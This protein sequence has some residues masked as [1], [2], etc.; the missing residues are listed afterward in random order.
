M[1][2]HS[3]SILQEITESVPV[4][5]KKN[6]VESKAVHAISSAIA[7]MRLLEREY[8]EE[9]EYLIK[10]FFSSLRGRDPN[11]FSR[12]MTKIQEASDDAGE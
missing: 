4:N 8:P 12:S 3:K 2:K 9:S 11:R 6:F 5:N 1:N 10:R 7:L